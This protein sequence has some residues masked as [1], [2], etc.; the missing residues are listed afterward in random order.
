[1]RITFCK[2]L[3]AAFTICLSSTMFAQRVEFKNIDGEEYAILYYTNT[4][5]HTFIPPNG[6]TQVDVLVVA[7][8]GSGATNTQYSSA[9]GGGGGAG[10]FIESL[11]LNIS[12]LGSNIGIT[13]GAGG[14]SNKN[15]NTLANGENGENSTFGDLTALGGGGGVTNA[16]STFEV[17]PS[18]GSGG[19]GRN[20]GT[21]G[22]AL[23]PSSPSGGLGNNGGETANAET[24]AGAGGGGGAGSAGGD[25]GV[26]DSA[27]M[28]PPTTGGFG[29]TGGD[30]A[31][32]SITGD[33][34]VYAAGGGA[35]G[36]C[37]EDFGVGG[38]NG[39]GGNGANNDNV[40]TTGA[41]NTGSGGG[42]GNNNNPAA[43][44]ADGIVIVRYKVSEVTGPAEIIYE[45]TSAEFFDDITFSEGIT[46]RIE[47][48]VDVN[49]DVDI[50]VSPNSALE[51]NGDLNLGDNATLTLEAN[52]DG[53]YAM[54][55]FDGDLNLGSGNEIKQQIHFKGG[56]HMVSAPFVPSNAGF[57]G[58][59]SEDRHPNAYNFFAWNGTGYD[60]VPNN[61]ASIDVGRGY[62]GFVGRNFDLNPNRV[63][64]FRDAGVTEYEGIP[65]KEAPSIELELDTADTTGQSGG[66]GTWSFLVDGQILG[67]WNMLGNPFTAA[68]DFE[69]T[70][71]DTDPDVE[72]AF[73]VFDPITGTDGG[74]FQSWSTAGITEPYVAPFQAYW[75]RVRRSATLPMQINAVSMSDNSVIPT[76]HPEFFRS[77]IDKVVIRTFEENDADK[78]DHTVVAFVDGTSD[79]FDNG[80]DARK[81]P[82]SEPFPTIYTTGAV[83][84]LANNAID[85]GV[86]HPNDKRSID[87]GFIAPKHGANYTVRFDD[88]YLLNTYAVFLEDKKLNHFHNLV[89][90]DYTFSNDT[91]NADRFVLHF[92]TGALSSDLEFANKA[93]LRA[94]VYQGRAYIHPNVDLGRSDIRM[95]DMSGRT[96]FTTSEDLR[97]D[98]RHEIDLPQLRA[99]MY[100]LQVGSEGIIKVVVQ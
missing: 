80:W 36:C 78:A 9:G 68:L 66:G 28:P 82:N 65:N 16:N 63:V 27:G 42:G 62:Y 41:P 93:N 92:R 59:V 8:G 76:A 83:D 94:W 51:V 13:V 89:A 20:S 60:L 19:G 81:M 99:G 85:Y 29:G 40:A 45:V 14:I 17:A 70:N 57:F 33:N 72:Q 56:W 35:G 47:S 87:M 97:K 39:V 96:V 74:T 50:V 54:L 44:G 73:Y 34:V 2:F 84:A 91:G 4:G 64:G 3:F 38:S 32:S 86:N 1:M 11:D 18:G 77:S 53:E 100:L 67:G 30:G 31:I 71:L 88:D 37:F 55:K 22:I 79:D 58:E 95:M 69:T 98:E 49:E 24:G 21:A 7:G 5:S 26:V 90:S 61:A 75:V 10:G 52:S 25:G 12:S 6:I 46:V 48:N 43:D 23:Q 15:T